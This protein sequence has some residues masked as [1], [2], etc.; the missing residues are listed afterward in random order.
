MKSTIII[1]LATCRLAA[2]AD[3]TT[4]LAVIPHSQSL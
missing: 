2:T 4:E 1:G 3:A